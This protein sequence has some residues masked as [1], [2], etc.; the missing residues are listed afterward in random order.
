MVFR[1]TT[2][3]LDSLSRT[4]CTRRHLCTRV[5]CLSPSFLIITSPL[6]TSS[7]ALLRQCGGAQRRTRPKTLKRRRRRADRSPQAGPSN[8]TGAQTA[9]KR[10]PGSRVTKDF[11]R[12]GKTLND[13]TPGGTGTGFKKRSQRYTQVSEVLYLDSFN[14]TATGQERSAPWQRRRGLLH[15]RKSRQPKAGPLL[16][17]T[18]PPN[19]YI[20]YR[21]THRRQHPVRVGRGGRVRKDRT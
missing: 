4:L 21:T 14:F 18:Q 15:Q 6:L 13:G 1:S 8:H 7:P 9:K 5:P 20:P 19:P 17:F 12:N 3:R 11:G 10:R 2:L 16:T